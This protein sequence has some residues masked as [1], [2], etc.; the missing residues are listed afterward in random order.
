MPKAETEPEARACLALLSG[1]T[2]RVYT[3]IA[4]RTSDGRVRERLVETRVRFKL[5]ST[6]EID[7]YIVCGEWKGKAGGY[8]A[9]GRAARF[10]VSIIGS[11]SSV[12]GLPLYETANLL[13][14]ARA[15]EA[16]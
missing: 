14:G 15:G 2:H 7:A 10:I 5:L 4:L 3:A 9:Q 12:V 1:R 16:P 6:A 8:A 11:Y 13:D